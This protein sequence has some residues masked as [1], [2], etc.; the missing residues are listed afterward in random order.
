M[1][2]IY[3][4][5]SVKASNQ[6][7]PSGRHG[8]VN[9]SHFLMGYSS[10]SIHI[11]L[12]SPIC[13]LDTQKAWFSLGILH[14][15]GNIAGLEY[16]ICFLWVHRQLL[17]FRSDEASKLQIDSMI[18]RLHMA[19]YGWIT[20]Y[21]QY[22]SSLKFWATIGFKTIRHNSELGASK[23]RGSES[24]QGFQ[25]FNLLRM[26]IHL[27]LDEGT[28]ILSPYIPRHVPIRCFVPV[29]CHVP[30]CHSQ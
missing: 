20:T 30:V 19:S 2:Y 9:T 16:W 27:V 10:I 28:F 3:I 17:R 6:L 18:F 15:F 8:N 13:F 14:E 5:M 7:L 24:H 11:S 21:F 23:N 12:K 26:L 4:Y 25:R 29:W 22:C 1:I